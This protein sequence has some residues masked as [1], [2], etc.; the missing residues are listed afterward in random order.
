MD[1]INI[2]QTER[3]KNNIL[4]KKITMDSFS[5]K[6]TIEKPK[7]EKNETNNI[8]NKVI[9]YNENNVGQNLIF[10]CPNEFCPFIPSLKYYE[11]TQSIATKCRL[12]HE[13]HL[14]LNKLYEIV[15]NKMNTVKL[16]N[17]C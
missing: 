9:N 5:I 7:E 16:C 8:L 6:T 2:E 17:I 13:Y 12:G 3:N 4:N 11:F 1:L 15:F 14:S 10:E